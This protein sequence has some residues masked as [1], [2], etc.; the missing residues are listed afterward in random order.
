MLF[1][2][3]VDYCDGCSD[4]VLIS[5]ENTQRANLTLRDMFEGY[6]VVG[7]HEYDVEAIIADQYRYGA[8]LSTEP[9]GSY[10]EETN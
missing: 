9:S 6:A 7:A 10:S 2:Y 5:A 1:G 3:R 4:F 8:V